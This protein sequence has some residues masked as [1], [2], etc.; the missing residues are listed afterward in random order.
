MVEALTPHVVCAYAHNFIYI[1]DKSFTVKHRSSSIQT[2]IDKH[3]EITLQFVLNQSLS[4]LASLKASS[5]VS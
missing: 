3:V 5:V 2:N 1:T 4:F